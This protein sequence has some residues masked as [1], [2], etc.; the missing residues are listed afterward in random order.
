MQATAR[1]GGGGAKVAA[2][3]NVD[4]V[5]DRRDQHRRDQRSRR[6]RQPMPGTAGLVLHSS[7][8]VQPGQARSLLL[9]FDQGRQHQPQPVQRRRAGTGQRQAQVAVAQVRH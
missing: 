8:Q 7:H 9:G 1:N 5:H 4:P 6:R 3:P 2:Q